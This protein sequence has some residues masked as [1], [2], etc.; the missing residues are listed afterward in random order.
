MTKKYPLWTLESTRGWLEKLANDAEERQGKF[1]LK[2]WQNE[3]GLPWNSLN[4]YAQKFGLYRTYVRTR[5]RLDPKAR[6]K[7]ICYRRKWK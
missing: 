4:F 1:T 2:Q 3:H 5:D 6:K 7:R